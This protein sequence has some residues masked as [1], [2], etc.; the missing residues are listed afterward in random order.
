MFLDDITN[1]CASV[2][3]YIYLYSRIP[4]ARNKYEKNTVK[5]YSLSSIPRGK[6]F[7]FLSTLTHLAHALQ[8][9]RKNCSQA[10][11]QSRCERSARISTARR[12]TNAVYTR[13]GFKEM[14]KGGGKGTD[15]RALNRYRG[16][17]WSG[18]VKGG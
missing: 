12:Q 3:I 5:S 17:T 6:I 13:G 9:W 18:I 15:K 2:Y 8:D 14:P 10:A 7:T 11:L 16:Q 4:F 1:K